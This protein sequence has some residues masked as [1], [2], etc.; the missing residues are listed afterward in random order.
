MKRDMD[1]ARNT[2][3]LSN[4]A[5]P[6][7]INAS[8]QQ[9]VQAGLPHQVAGPHQGTVPNQGYQA[10]NRVGGQANNFA[11]VGQVPVMGAPIQQMQPAFYY[12]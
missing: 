11:V 8:H 6:D 3:L 4:Q 1:R 10:P 7:V 12:D 5:N 9:P 2:A